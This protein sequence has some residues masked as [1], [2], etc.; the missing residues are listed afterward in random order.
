M[1][2]YGGIIL[3]LALLITGCASLGDAAKDLLVL[4]ATWETPARQAGVF[5]EARVQVTRLD[6]AIASRDPLRVRAVL[7]SFEPVYREI[8]ASVENPTPEQ[9]EFHERALELWGAVE[10]GEQSQWL[11]LADIILRVLVTRI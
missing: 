7:L 3:T 11:E 4:R 5:E 6:E 10:Q 2:A 8:Y 9:V 1:N